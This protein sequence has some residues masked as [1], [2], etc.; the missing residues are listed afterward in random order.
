M[1]PLVL[2]LQLDSL[3]ADTGNDNPLDR[4]ISI[5]Q[6][7]LW[8]GFLNSQRCIGLVRGQGR[9]LLLARRGGTEKRLKAGFDRGP[10]VAAGSGERRTILQEAFHK[11]YR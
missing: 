10:N 5:H 2:T 8:L 1:P 9:N 6:L 7:D 4:T 11:S 3:A